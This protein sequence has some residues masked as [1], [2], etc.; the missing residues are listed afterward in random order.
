M[1]AAEEKVTQTT[2]QQNIVYATLLLVALTDKTAGNQFLYKME[3]HME[4]MELRE[5]DRDVRHGRGKKSK[6]RYILQ[7]ASTLQVRIQ[8]MAAEKA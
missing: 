4:N 8:E 6:G 7:L 5:R 2:E 1:E 3:T